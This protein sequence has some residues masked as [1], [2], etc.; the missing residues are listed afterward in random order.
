MSSKTWSTRLAIVCLG[1]ILASAS[2]DSL[3]LP[4]KAQDENQQPS[5]L[6]AVI[7]LDINPNQRKVFAL[8]SALATGILDHLAQRDAA[9][10][11]VTFGSQDPVLQIANARPSDAIDA[12]KSVNLEQS[13]ER[14]FS[15]HMY[16]TM[17]LALSQFKD[18]S[19]P[20]SLL[21]IAE[22]RE[23]FGRK[24]FKQIVSRAHQLR[25]SCYVALVASHS[26]RGSKSILMYGFYLS[27]LARKTHGRCIEV[28]DR[29]KKL[30]RFV[31]QF[32][33]DILNHSQTYQTGRN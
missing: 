2:T 31:E 5:S 15:I 25:V 20:K 22:G 7:V 12:I 1:P 3:L 21:I 28:G 6:Q 19:R 29:Q 27:D 17:D 18:D 11:L 9:V 32:S 10:S 26:L 30:P 16:E 24:Q 14:Y 8:E 4:S 13:R 23:D 33:T